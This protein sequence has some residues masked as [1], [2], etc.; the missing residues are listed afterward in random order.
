MIGMAA[1]YLNRF[2]SM[3]AAPGFTLDLSVSRPKLRS[4]WLLA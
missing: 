2:V 1:Y 4:P 3:V